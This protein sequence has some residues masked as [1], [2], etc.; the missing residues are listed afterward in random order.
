MPDVGLFTASEPVPAETK[1]VIRYSVEV[2]GLEVY[3]ESYDVEKLAAE[4]LEDEAKVVELWARRLKCVA[5]CR[6]RR[7]FS[8]CVTRC[9]TDGQSCACGHEECD[10]I[11]F[12]GRATD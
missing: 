11:D 6:N 12:T 2:G 3:N 9:L 4:L 7:G 10:A 5:A 1:I 8:A